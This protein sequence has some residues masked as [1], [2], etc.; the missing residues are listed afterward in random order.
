[1]QLTE[2]QKN[3]LND[4]DIRSTRKAGMW[5]HS[6]N[7]NNTVEHNEKMLDL[8]EEGKTIKEANLL[9]SVIMQY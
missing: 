3:R 1:M 4:M 7:K 6:N 5:R 2:E 9:A 8:I